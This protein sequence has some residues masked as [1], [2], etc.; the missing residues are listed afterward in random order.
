MY[1]LR[2]E[3][4]IIVIIKQLFEMYL[5]EETMEISERFSPTFQA[6][7]FGTDNNATTIDTMVAV[8]E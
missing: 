2:G 1:R 8:M 3:K 4:K 5:T 6:L 7:E